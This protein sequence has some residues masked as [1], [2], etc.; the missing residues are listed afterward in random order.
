MRFVAM[1]LIVNFIAVAKKI[2]NITINKRL[3]RVTPLVTIEVI[4]LITVSGMCSIYMCICILRNVK[5]LS[6]HFA[7]FRYFAFNLFSD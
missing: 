6:I 2:E 4:Y 1:N 7:S 5:Q 3:L